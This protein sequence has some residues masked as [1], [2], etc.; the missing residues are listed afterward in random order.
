[1]SSAVA[2]RILLFAALAIS[3]G[4]F[5]SVLS[6]TTWWVVVAGACLIVTLVLGIARAIRL[7]RG[8][9]LL[10]ATVTAVLVLTGFFAPATAL[11]GVVPWLNTV[12]Y[13]AAI[14]GAGVQ[15][16]AEQHIPAEPV[17]GIVFLLTAGFVALTLVLEV[18]AVSLRR[19]ALVGIPL[20]A[21][22]AVPSLI[23]PGASQPLLLIAVAVV[24]LAVLVLGTGRRVT[25]GA[26]AVGAAAL[27]ASLVLGL[28]LPAVQAEDDDASD[29]SGY[30]VGVNPFISLGADLRR[31]RSVEAFSYFTDSEVPQYFTLTVLE[32]FDGLRWEPTPPGDGDDPS[33]I[34]EVPG[35]SPGAEVV[36]TT[37]EIEAGSIRGQWLPVPYAPRVITGLTGDWDYSQE[38]L[39]VS[40]QE[41][42]LSGQEYVVLAERAAPTVQELREA[43]SGGTTLDRWRVLPDRMPDVIATTAREVVG[44]AASSYD[45]AVA[46]QSWFRSSEFRYS[47]E[48]PVEEGYDG[49]GADVVAEFLDKRSGYCVHFASAMAL[50]ARSLGIPA[51]IGVGFIP[52]SRA[53]NFERGQSRW[54]V[55]TDDLHA[56]PELYFAGQ[57]W[58]RF[59]PTPGRGTAPDYTLGGGST[60]RP[61]PTSSA[62]PTAT[63]SPT[64]SAGS[65]TDTDDDSSGGAALLRV[66][67][68]ALPWVGA[69]LLIVAIGAVPFAIRRIR[70]AARL[71]RLERTGSAATAWR[72]IRDAAADAGIATTDSRTV[73]ETA[74]VLAERMDVV[75]A[76]SL[77]RVRDALEAQSYAR[78]PVR[79]EAADV[80]RVVHALFASLSRGARVR[81]TLLP[82]SVFA[83]TPRGEEPGL[84]EVAGSPA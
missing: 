10:A 78:T 66:L 44:D 6:G 65:V 38:S 16:I 25:A 42:N 36:R 11:L 82:A 58:V 69:A 73:R 23:D 22:L 48:A 45:Q 9:P 50:M 24:Y 49:T 30:A 62:T 54:T 56:W 52:G 40:S 4:S 34:G 41:A 7:P 1:V 28:A 68:A 75:G 71:R 26:V 51:R 59:E 20:L 2:T 21:I 31:P 18:L 77:A 46:L 33:A 35:R 70:R 3:A 79:A 57:G 29:G 12:P 81:A 17:A 47:E 19:P 27:V 55:T 64:P 84:R 43:G 15:S 74:L 61:Q 83:V 13:L 67:A 72:E 80:R 14:G 32:D 63:A 37:T 76:D 39:A 53:W 8:L 60:S 5:Q